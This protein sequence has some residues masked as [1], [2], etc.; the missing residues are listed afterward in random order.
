[1]NDQLNSRLLSL[2]PGQLCCDTLEIYGIPQKL[3]EQWIDE[4]LVDWELRGFDD[5]IQGF[6]VVVVEDPGWWFYR[7]KL[8][9]KEVIGEEQ[10][11]MVE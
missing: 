1:M 3:V 6:L 11:S 2:N 8:I 9:R 4:G 5:A 10:F 7:A